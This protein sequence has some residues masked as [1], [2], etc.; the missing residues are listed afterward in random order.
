MSTLTMRRA[1]ATL[2]AVSAGAL[3]VTGCSAGGG[4][5][6][7]GD[8]IGRQDA[9]RQHVEY[10]FGDAAASKG[11]AKPIKG[12]EKGGVVHVYQRDS[13]AHLDPAQIYVSDEGSLSTL[14][15]RRLT[16][17]KR[18]AEGNYTLVGDL[19]TDSGQMSDD[20]KTWTYHLKDGIKF[21]D[22][23]EITSKDVRHTFER[24]FAD[25]ITDGPYY[26]QQW[27]ADT[28]DATEWRELLKGGPYD[29]DHLPDSI[30]E[31]PD[32][33]TV[34]FHFK[35]PVPDLPYAL[36]MPGYGIVPDGKQDT[37]QKYDKDP[38]CS[39]PYK[40]AEFKPGKSMKLVR[41]TE[42]DPATDP[43]RH[44]YPKAFEIQ[45]NV[46]FKA[47]TQRLIADTGENK[48]AISFNNGVDSGHMQ[49]VRSNP[50]V[51]KRSVAG[52]QSYVAVMDFNMKR[53]KDKKVRKAIAYALPA[54]S[55]I[56]AFGG[57][58]GGEIA[59]NYISPTLAGHKDTDPFG[60]KK[61]PRG[62]I[63]KAKKLLKESGKVG[64]KLTFAY[65][66]SPEWSEYAVAVADTLDKVGFNVQKKPLNADTYYDQIGK[67]DNDFDIY[68]SSWGADWPS[69]STVVPPVYDGR[70]IQDG[71]PNYAHYNNPEINK[72]MD[73]VAQIQDPDKAAAAWMKLSDRILTEDVPGVPLMY[74]KQ[75]QLHGSKIGGVVYSDILHAVDPT[76][77]YVKQ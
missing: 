32:D 67:V 60:K 65:Q 70:Q 5:G 9:K 43:S 39:G 48:T 16:E 47:S 69:M 6:G 56:T 22:G 10:A 54:Q 4:G 49:Q 33:K 8:A 41:N 11:P 77:L 62:D 64:K 46:S 29:G 19:A 34:V 57:T 12:A 40:I 21:E 63:E 26:I 44:Q 75:L 36:A 74:Y 28:T 59:G 15:F 71:S 55:L 1:R 45:F 73:R 53:L 38:V 25:F 76:Q 24:M 23:S 50:E 66:N 51:K 30:L 31:T 2:V 7:D 72:E 14:L 17:Y 68:H 3:L 27:L 37:K 35:K 42:W 18:D 52:Y 58:A 13:Y 61:N 20:G